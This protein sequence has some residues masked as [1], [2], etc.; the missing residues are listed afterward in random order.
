MADEKEI[1]RLIDR[2]QWDF[3]PVREHAINALKKIGKPAVPLLFKAHK[4][5]SVTSE[6]GEIVMKV[7]QEICFSLSSSDQIS[8]SR[9]K[10]WEF[11][12]PIEWVVNHIIGDLKSSVEQD[13][14]EDN[15][16]DALEKIKETTSKVRK[17]DKGKKRT[18]I[19]GELSTLTQEIH[20]KMNPEKKKFHKP[21]KHQLVRKTQARKVIRNVR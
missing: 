18:E 15:F 19:L 11:Y 3:Q 10:T 1:Q 4:S 14:I 17:A 2:L 9:Y 7:L 13:L 20:A 12:N 16:T 5:F 21:V 6:K 8:V